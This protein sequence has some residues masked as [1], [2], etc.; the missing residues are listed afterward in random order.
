MMRKLYSE[1]KKTDL[2]KNFTASFELTDEMKGQ[3]MEVVDEMN[4]TLVDYANEP[5]H[6]TKNESP[7]ADWGATVLYI[8][9]KFYADLCVGCNNFDLDCPTIWDAYEDLGYDEDEQD[10]E[11]L[12]K[13]VEWSYTWGVKING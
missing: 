8:K 4:N 5:A 13:N 2:I 7:A 6:N 11:E 12:M 3:L 10:Y 9:G 1:L